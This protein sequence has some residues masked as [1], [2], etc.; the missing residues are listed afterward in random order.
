VEAHA[1]PGVGEV[2]EERAVGRAPVGLLEELGVGGDRPVRV[3]IDPGAFGEAVVE[4][5]GEVPTGEVRG[6][7]GGVVDLDEL[8]VAGEGIERLA[9]Q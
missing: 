7:L 3:P 4:R 1:A 8:G 5:G 6:A 9:L 2:A